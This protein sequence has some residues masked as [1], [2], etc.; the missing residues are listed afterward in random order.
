MKFSIETDDQSEAVAIA[1]VGDL[2]G[3]MR[4]INNVVQ[5]QV[6]YGDAEDDREVLQ[7]IKNDVQN[8]LLKLGV[9]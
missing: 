3:L 4:D 5:N 1:F 7:D 9:Y 6:S 8:M 2:V